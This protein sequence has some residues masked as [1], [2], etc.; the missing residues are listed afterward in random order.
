MS[1]KRYINHFAFK[2]YNKLAAKKHENFFMS[3]LSISTALTIC[4]FGARNET[5]KELKDALELS[6]LSDD[7]ILKINEEYQN[8][9]K[10]E[11]FKGFISPHKSTIKLANKIYTKEGFETKQDFVELASKHFQSEI[12]P[13][14]FSHPV[15]ASDKVNKWISEQTHNRINSMVS[16]SCFGDLSGMLLVN[17]IYFFAEW[18]DQF[19]EKETVKKDFHDIDGKTSKVDMMHL[20]K[21][22][23]YIH[24]P[25]DIPASMCSLTFRDGI[26]SMEIILPDKRHSLDEIES[27]L[28]PEILQS[29]SDIRKV[30]IQLPRFKL[31]YKTELST[32][33]EEMGV[34]L[35]FQNG[36]ADFS[37]ISND[38]R[39]LAIS[40]IV[41]QAFIDVNENGVEAAAATEFIWMGAAIFRDEPVDFFCDRPFMFIISCKNTPIFIGKFVKPK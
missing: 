21:R 9:L 28:T 1:E 7:E 23:S 15:E 41:H 18:F 8:N 11:V 14:D 39:G 22:M 29:R 25:G 33:L 12:E 34:K 3:P 26:T 38:P 4:Y 30:N 35:A 10:G 20:R 19:S 37:A 16:P 5:A 17:T 40:N 2:L 31:E 27:K 24:H 36:V 32:H 13:I 6:N